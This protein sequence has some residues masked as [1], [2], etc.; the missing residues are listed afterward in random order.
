MLEKEVG[1]NR[2]ITKLVILQKKVYKIYSNL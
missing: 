2:F 1:Q